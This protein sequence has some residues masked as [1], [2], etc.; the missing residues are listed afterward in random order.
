MTKTPRNSKY[1]WIAIIT[2]VAVTSILVVGTAVASD[3]VYAGNYRVRGNIA[4]NNCGNEFLPFNVSCSNKSSQVQGD[5]NAAALTSTQKTPTSALPDMIFDGFLNI[6]EAIITPFGQTDPP[7]GNTNG[8]LDAFLKTHGLIPQDGQGGAF[9]YGILTNNTSTGDGSLIVTT[10]HAGVLDSA[11]QQDINDPVW[12]NHMIQLVDDASHCG[13]DKS[14]EPNPAVGN[15]T[16]Q[17]PGH[18]E[19]AG[20]TAHLIGIPNQFSSPSSF[21]PN[22][23]N[24]TYEPG[25]VVEN[26]VS[27]KLAPVPSTGGSAPDGTLKA[28]CVTDITPAEKVID[29][30]IHS[31]GPLLNYM[32]H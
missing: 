25:N 32:D 1:L 18:V 6:K 28:V 27:F 16:W 13:R 10:T 7:V 15:I 14:G 19:I 24:Q 30:S 3:K 4:T 29:N 12:H 31:T 20:K 23:P 26:V 8:G 9:G 22:G 2:A 21:D 11:V 5:E 17:Q